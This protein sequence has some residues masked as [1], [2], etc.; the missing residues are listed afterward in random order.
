MTRN[1]EHIKTCRVSGNCVYSELKYAD[2]T[3]TQR[4]QTHM[5]GHICTLLAHVCMRALIHTLPFSPS[6][7]FFVLVK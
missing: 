1:F 3:L 4:I 2:S 6:I 7:D 5:H